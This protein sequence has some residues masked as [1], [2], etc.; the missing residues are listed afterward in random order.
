MR[1]WESIH[2]EFSEC[3]NLLPGMTGCRSTARTRYW[4]L[5]CWVHKDSL[6]VAPRHRHRISRIP[7]VFLRSWEKTIF[8]CACA[9]ES[10]IKLANAHFFHAGWLPQDEILYHQSIE[11][12]PWNIDCCLNGKSSLVLAFI[13]VTTKKTS[14]WTSYCTLFFSASSFSEFEGKPCC[15]IP[16]SIQNIQLPLVNGRYQTPITSRNTPN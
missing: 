5:S 3:M 2:F 4:V 10:K 7:A 8:C 12:L 15:R 6:H 9:V 13:Y 14:L 11:L 16:W 1:P